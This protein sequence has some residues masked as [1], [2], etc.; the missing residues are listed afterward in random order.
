MISFDLSLSNK[1]PDELEY[2][3]LLDFTD[4]DCSQRASKKAKSSIEVTLAGIAIS[5]TSVN[6]KYRYSIDFSLLSELKITECKFFDPSNA[7]APIVKTESGMW[8][9]STLP[10]L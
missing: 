5:F 2:F 10:A 6:A 3:L 8:I 4:I 9:V 7:P 1:T